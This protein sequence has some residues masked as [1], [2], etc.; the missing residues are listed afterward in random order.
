VGY[1]ERQ[2]EEGDNVDPDQDNPVT[3]IG[4]DEPTQTIGANLLL[5]HSP[6]GLWGAVGYAQRDFAAPEG[7]DG[8][9]ADN[10]W[11]AIGINYNWTGM[12]ATA[13][14]GEYQQTQDLVPG[15]E[16]NAFSIGFGQDIDAIGANAFVKYSHAEA[17]LDAATFGA[18]EVE[19]FSAVTAGMVVYF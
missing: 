14:W 18:L 12:G 8:G 17:D 1:S 15:I 19:D 10:I 3:F 16:V 9:D 5:Y 2:V 6:S 13:I 11:T 7:V 4:E